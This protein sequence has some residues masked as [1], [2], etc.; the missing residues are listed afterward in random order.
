MGGADRERI[1]RRKFEHRYNGGMGCEIEGFI[2][3]G[4]GA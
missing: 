2:K 3:G 4:I 1:N